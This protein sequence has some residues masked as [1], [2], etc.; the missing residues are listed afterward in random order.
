M[1]SPASATPYTNG[2][3]TS[4]DGTVGDRQFGHGPGIIAI[5]G[6][7]QAAQNFTKLAEALS[8]LFTAYVP[9]R[10]GR[11]SSGPPGDHYS[12]RSECEDIAALLS[13]TGSHNVF[14]LRASA[15]IALQA[16]LTLP[17]IRKAAIFGPPLL[18]NHSTPIDWL[19]RYDQEIAEG[20]LGQ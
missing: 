16:A 15:L 1:T 9:D 4:R 11:G 6:G 8:D 17:T 13:L 18:V 10:R 3:I 20:R 19:A 2:A 12:I 14:G 7:M 5:Q